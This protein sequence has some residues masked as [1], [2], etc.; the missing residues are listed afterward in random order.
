MNTEERLAALEAQMR[1]AA[2]RQAI[3]DCI[4]RNSR[5]NDRFDV[6]LVTSS[7][8]VDGVHELGQKQISGRE[9]GEHANH[10]HAA[11]FDATLHNVTMHSCEV[12]GDVAHAESYSLGV[13]LDKGAETGRILAG[14]YIDRLEKRDGEWRIVLRRATVEVAIEGKATLPSGAPLPGSGYLRGGRDHTDLSY[15]RPLTTEGGGRW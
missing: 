11:L 5:G 4:K 15:A 10:A 12:D 1:D 8:H 13:F 3:F 6:E 2:D 7:Y 9:Y 14:R